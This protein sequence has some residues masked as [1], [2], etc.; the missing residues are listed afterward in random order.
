MKRFE[1]RR[2]FLL[3]FVAFCC[4]LLLFVTYCYFLKQF[5]TV[6]N[7]L[8]LFVT[9]W[10][11]LKPFGTIWNDSKLVVYLNKVVSRA[12][13]TSSRL[14]STS[15]VLVYYNCLGVWL[16]CMYSICRRIGGLYWT[17][18]WETTLGMDIAERKR[19]FSS[20]RKFL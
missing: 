13:E 15:T 14:K 19:D 4:F 10:N 5:E 9:F 11:I 20:W 8:L 7:D 6:W 17:I 12:V 3:F 2:Y 18:S 16:H 1:M